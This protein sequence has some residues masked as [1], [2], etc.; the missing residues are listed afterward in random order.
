MTRDY[1]EQ[2]TRRLLLAQAG[3]ELG[4][5]GAA[6]SRH[7]GAFQQVRGLLP[8]LLPGIAHQRYLDEQ[9]QHNASA[10]PPALS[11]W[12]AALPAL[13]ATPDLVE[14][15]RQ[16]RKPLA[17]VARQYFRTAAALGIDWLAESIRELKT[18][19][20][21]QAVARERLYTACLDGQR[22][23]CARALRERAGDGEQLTRW[24]ERLGAPGA[25]WRLTL[26]ELRASAAP[27]LAALMA[28]AEALRNLAQAG[29]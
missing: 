11:A 3:A 25:Q 1:V 12:L 6:V 15:S 29:G 16:A 7:S 24:C 18:T 20:A 26:R 13:R 4:D 21:W 17:S 28:G 19:G 8:A 10:L 22:S 2:L 23:L 5:I 9:A 27:D 14:I